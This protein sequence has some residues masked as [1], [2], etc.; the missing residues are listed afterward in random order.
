MDQFERQKVERQALNGRMTLMFGGIFLL[1]SAITSTLM[2]GI[3]FF[4]TA[5]QAD[6]GVSEYVELLETAGV[7]SNFLRVAGIC[8]LLVGIYEVVTGFFAV[9]NSN[10]IDK[11]KFTLKMVVSLLIVEVLLQIYLFFTGLMNLGIL[12]TAVLLPLFMLWGVTR[13]RKVAKADP[14]RIYA[15]KQ[16]SKEKARQQAAAAPKKSIRERAAMQARL[17]EDTAESSAE[18]NESAEVT[19]STAETKGAEETKGTEEIKETEVAEGTETSESI[20]ETVENT[21]E[22]EAV[23]EAKNQEAEK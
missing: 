5:Q 12:F 16:A 9:K 18:E 10:R 22:S 8:F 15:V 7:S 11:S 21:E 1:F 4:M 13:L 2:Y 3:N 20:K 19:E 6:K 14:E 23:E 17:D